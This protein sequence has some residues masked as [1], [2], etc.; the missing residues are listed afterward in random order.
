MQEMKRELTTLEKH[1]EV[2]RN[3]SI[4]ERAVIKSRR[5]HLHKQIKK[6]KKQIAKLEQILEKHKGNYTFKEIAELMGQ[7]QS[8]I[9]YHYHRIRGEIAKK[10]FDTGLES[11]L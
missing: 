11:L 9:S 1:N 7:S 10:F 3:S 6:R 2:M 8:W 4:G 5:E